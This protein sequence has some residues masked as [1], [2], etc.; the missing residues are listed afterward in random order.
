[1][2]TTVCAEGSNSIVSLAV[3]VEFPGLV[4]LLDSLPSSQD[5]DLVL[6]GDSLAVEDE[7]GSY[8]ISLP[9]V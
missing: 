8:L 4:C 7:E 9:R 6:T 1:M 5:S 2:H 3:E